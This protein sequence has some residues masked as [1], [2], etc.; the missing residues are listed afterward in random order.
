[1]NWHWV[2][3]LAGSNTGPASQ[4]TIAQ[5]ANGGFVLAWEQE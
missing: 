2:R 3:E 4:P 1:M 5:A